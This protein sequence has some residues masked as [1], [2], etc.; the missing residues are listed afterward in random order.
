MSDP[1]PR[2]VKIGGS[3]T[4]RFSRIIPA[5]MESGCPLLIVPGGGPF[6]DAVR[7]LGLDNDASHWMAIAA[8][9][10]TGWWISSF[11][12]EPTER[13]GIPGGISVLL[14]YAEMRRYDPLPHSW[15]VTSDV[16]A[17]WVASRLG[18]D[19]LLL[20]S[21]DGLY[22]GGELAEEVTM[23]APC[24]EVDP[25]FLPFVFA[26]RVSVQVVNG[27]HEDRVVGALRRTAVRGTVIHP[28]F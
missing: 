11:G 15:E 16:I 13:I 17:A 1:L 28:R 12:V 24:D 26:Q 19:L 6:A 18:L 3:L 4:D 2:V 9:E 5:L 14:P 21:V 22:T 23:P 20:K 25:L 8:M 27:R 7:R 10:Q